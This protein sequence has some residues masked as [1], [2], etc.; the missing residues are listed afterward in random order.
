MSSNELEGLMHTFK[1][2]HNR[3]VEGETCTDKEKNGGLLAANF[4]QCTMF[5]PR[6]DF[7]RH[8]QYKLNYVMDKT[9]TQSHLFSTKIVFP[10]CKTVSLMFTVLLN[11]FLMHQSDTADQ[12]DLSVTSFKFLVKSR[13]IVCLLKPPPTV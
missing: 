7:T 1:E 6:R 5:W 13:P 12:L 8:S 11:S 2:I 10:K 4:I 9:Y 3:Y